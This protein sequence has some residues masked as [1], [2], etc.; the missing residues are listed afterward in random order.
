MSLS[1]LLGTTTAM[2]LIT[3]QTQILLLGSCITVFL[4]ALTLFGLLG[5]IV[6]IRTMESTFA[7][8]SSKGE[9][10]ENNENFASDDEDDN[11]KN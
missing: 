8:S 2:F 1:L 4:R 7:V 9:H 5:V 3:Y 6:L 11:A 10:D